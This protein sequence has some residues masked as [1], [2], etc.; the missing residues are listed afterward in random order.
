MKMS[1]GLFEDY[2]AKNS[3]S[4]TVQEEGNKNDSVDEAVSA[5]NM[6]FPEFEES[7][8]I[9]EEKEEDKEEIRDNQAAE[10]ML[11]ILH[12]IQSN[13][14]NI[15]EKV[16][17]TRF[18]IETLAK[19]VKDGV[20]ENNELLTNVTAENDSMKKYMEQKIQ[21][22]F[23][24]LNEAIQEIQSGNQL[25]R[26]SMAVEVE[27]MNKENEKITFGLGVEA[28]KITKERLQ[29]G[30]QSFDG[31][32]KDVISSHA[33]I[34]D[35]V[36][37]IYQIMGYSQVGLWVWRWLLFIMMVELMQGVFHIEGIW[38]WIKVFT[39]LA[40]FF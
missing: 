4:G 38:S 34:V 20:Q 23:Q 25:L 14:T 40:L 19:A 29:E 11:Q 27:K 32:L 37:K 26:E 6:E 8:D 31:S 17:V 36:R 15:N 1:G 24:T 33:S 3:I 18:I 2:E 5:C 9:K 16:E 35:E 21:D 12:E 7:S 13:Y 30:L 10:P 28:V 39:G 22:S